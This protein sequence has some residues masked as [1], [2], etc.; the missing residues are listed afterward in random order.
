MFEKK[1]EPLKEVKK[2]ESKKEEKKEEV[3]PEKAF[4]RMICSDN[5]LMSRIRRAQKEDSKESKLYLEHLMHEKK[6]R[7]L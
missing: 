5:L 7:N 2:K 3:K 4:E 1:E 6:L